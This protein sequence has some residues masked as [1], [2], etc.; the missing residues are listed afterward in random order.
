MET[1]G[2]DAVSSYLLVVALATLLVAVL[3]WQPFRNKRTV[4]VWL[5]SGVVGVLLGSALPCAM[6]QL[7]G[8]EVTKAPERVSGENQVAPVP[9]GGA[10]M[11]C[12]MTG[13]PKTGTASTGDTKGAPMT[14]PM[15]GRPMSGMASTAD[16]K[17]GPM[18]CPMTGRP[19]SGAGDTKGMPGMGGSGGS[20]VKRNLTTLVQKLD[21]LT[22]GIDITLTAEQAAAVKDCLKDV[23]KSAKMSDDDAQAKHDQLVEALS[24]NQMACLQAIELPQPAPEGGMPG[25]MGSGASSNQDKDQN[26]FQQDAE[27]KAVK[28]LR[29]RL[30]SKGTA[31]KAETSKAPPAKAEA[32]K[33]AP[34]KVDVSKSAAAKS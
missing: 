19:I 13:G 21:L 32:P 22:G 11:T 4:S 14:C 6:M 25:M 27:G 9:C 1:L 16:T 12:P 29:E 17:G 5:A 24:Q 20:R 26:P 15:T 18:V 23:E 2:F 33:A 8:Y 3:V 31:P 28:S 34:P 7:K 10:G 30:A